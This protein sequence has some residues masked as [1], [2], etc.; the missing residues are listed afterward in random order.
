MKL[1]SRIA[2]FLARRLP[3]GQWRVTRF[4]AARDPALWDLPLPLP[5]IPGAVMRADLRDSAY[6][7]FLRHGC[8]PGQTGHDAFFRRA[9]RPSDT[10]FDI[11]ANVGYTML[12]FASLAGPKG[13]VIAL[14][15]GRRAFAALARN[16]GQTANATPLQVAASDR[17]GEAVFHE[18]E[19]SDLSSLEPV[20]GALTFTVPTARA[21]AI[22]GAHGVP[23]FVKIDVEGHEPGVLR[24]MAGMLGSARPPLVLF[25]ALDRQLRDRC[26]A[27]I[28]ELAGE[29][30]RILRLRGDGALEADI[31]RPGTNDYLFLPLWAESR[32]Q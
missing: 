18:T 10:V 16:A 29:S 2:L 22:A 32:V 11:G 19:L 5:A 6:M 31:D 9:V 15:P 24:G 4:A 1:V 14:E 26:V 17:D 7:N 30:G 25:E 27:T 13:K 21:D 8:I 28:R 23:D 20:A 3:R 12:L